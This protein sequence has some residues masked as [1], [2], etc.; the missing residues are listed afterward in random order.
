MSK[1]RGVDEKVQKVNQALKK[2]LEKPVGSELGEEEAR[3]LLR[4]V[5]EILSSELKRGVIFFRATTGF[6]LLERLP[7]CLPGT[8]KV[9]KKVKEVAR[10]GQG[11]LRAYLRYALAHPPLLP[12]SLSALS[13]QPSLLSSFFSD[14]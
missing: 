2:I 5:E 3:E 8:E 10:T 13:F 12:G 9:I 1:S 6:D 11:R 14:L 7:S 4:I